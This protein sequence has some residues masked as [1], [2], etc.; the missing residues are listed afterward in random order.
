MSNKITEAGALVYD[1]LGGIHI[2]ITAAS[3]EQTGLVG[4]AYYEFV[5]HGAAAACR[6]DTTAAAMADAGFTFVIAE[7][8]SKIVKNPAGNTLI[9]VIEA[10][11][12]ASTNAALTMTR[13]FPE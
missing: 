6:W 10:G 7:G 5:A 4:G 1:P 12:D 2:L 13:V 8:E 9:N 11:A 3:V